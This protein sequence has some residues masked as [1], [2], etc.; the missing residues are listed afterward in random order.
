MTNKNAMNEQKK[1][2]VTKA[3]E[4]QAGG[5]TQ[6]ALLD[7]AAHD[8]KASLNV[9]IGYSELMLDSALGKIT[10]DQRIGLKDILTNSQRMLGLVDSVKRL[11]KSKR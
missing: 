7:K 6:K 4:N 9:I 3:R 11:Q 10:E 8:L 2:P 5:N 1:T